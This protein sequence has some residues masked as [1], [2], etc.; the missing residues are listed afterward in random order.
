MT[1]AEKQGPLSVYR[2]L[3]SMREFQLL[4]FDHSPVE[5]MRWQLGGSVGEP[6]TDFHAEWGG[7]PRWPRSEFPNGDPSCPLLSGRIVDAL[8][9]EL[10][11]AG[12]LVRIDID[13]GG[14]VGGDYFL[15][16]VERVVDC[17]D[18]Q[19]SSSP[20]QLGRIKESV[21]RPDAL[22]VEL[23]AFRFPQFPTAVCWN[24]WMVERLR[25]LLGEQLESRLVWSEDSE[26]SPHPAPWGF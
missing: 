21:F 18:E 10:A 13:G 15:H 17:F 23:A 14:I 6:P 5:L 4:H 7:D 26:L 1:S 11:A 12:R 19:R 8:G 22:P 25:G 3:P 2:L 16:I 20:D 9:D 24:G